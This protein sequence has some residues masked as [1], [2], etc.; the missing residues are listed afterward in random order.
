M[1]S[2]TAKNGGP[3]QD[4]SDDFAD[5]PRLPQLTRDPTAPH[6]DYQ[7]DRHLNKQKVHGEILSESSS[8]TLSSAGLRKPV[9]PGRADGGNQSVAVSLHSFLTQNH[10]G[11]GGCGGITD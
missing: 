7:H 8:I 2:E 3:N 1:R 10:T 9:I 11:I 4:A 5:H 6:G